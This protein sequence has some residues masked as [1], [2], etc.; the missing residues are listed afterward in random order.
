MSATSSDTDAAT[1]MNLNRFDG[2][3]R[4]GMN[5]DEFERQSLVTCNISNFSVR[6]SVANGSCG[7]V[8]WR[9]QRRASPS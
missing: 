3:V 1:F 7:Q 9:R 6:R 2:A 8:A 4:L 5:L